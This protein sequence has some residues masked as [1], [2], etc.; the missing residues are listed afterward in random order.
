[1][2]T[3]NDK[4]F[5]DRLAKVHALPID[6]L[7]DGWVRDGSVRDGRLVKLQLLRFPGPELDVSGLDALES[8]RIGGELRR[9]ELGKL[10]QLQLLDLSD[11]KLQEL[12]VS[13]CSALTGLKVA[14]TQLTALPSLPWTLELLD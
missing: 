2:L 7:L 14:R 8:I 12:D 11:S 1:V 9:L 13:G 3:G 4:R 5:V 10:P 6:Y